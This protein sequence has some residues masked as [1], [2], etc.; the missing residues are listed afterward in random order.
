[1][2]KAIQI[3]NPNRFSKYLR[4]TARTSNSL[5][6]KVRPIRRTEIYLSRR[7]FSLPSLAL[8]SLLSLAEKRLLLTE[9]K[10]FLLF[11]QAFDE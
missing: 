2:L 3:C 6:K 5:K 10:K 1:M 4:N 11:F 9:N 7:T 8:S